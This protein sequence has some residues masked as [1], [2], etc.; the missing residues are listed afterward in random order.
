[1][2]IVGC[3]RKYQDRVL[4]LPLALYYADLP[5]FCIIPRRTSF[6]FTTRRTDTSDSEVFISPFSRLQFLDAVVRELAYVKQGVPPDRQ[7]VL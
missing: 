4:K 5:H 6:D 1:M 3:V 7:L 2:N